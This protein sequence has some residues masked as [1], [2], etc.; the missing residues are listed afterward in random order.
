M[1][2]PAKHYNS[3]SKEPDISHTTAVKKWLL[4]MRADEDSAGTHSG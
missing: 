3:A 4:L 1:H 2:H